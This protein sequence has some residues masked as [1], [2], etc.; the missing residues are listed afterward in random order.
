MESFNKSEIKSFAETGHRAEIPAGRFDIPGNSISDV[1]KEGIW[2]KVYDGTGKEMQ[3]SI[4]MRLKGEYC[5]HG[6]DFLV[7]K[8][9]GQHTTY[10]LKGCRINS[11][12]PQRG[13]LNS[14]FDSGMTF[15]NFGNITTYDKTFRQIGNSRHA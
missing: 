5:G 2:L 15:N 7:F 12:G 13:E 8:N 3:P 11:F 4:D 10:D 1:K 9:Y 14:V 6:K